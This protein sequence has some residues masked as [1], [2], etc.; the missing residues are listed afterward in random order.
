MGNFE[1]V[2]FASLVFNIE[3]NYEIETDKDKVN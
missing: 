2:P 1:D 3:P